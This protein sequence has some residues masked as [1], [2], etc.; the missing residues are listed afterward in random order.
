MRYNI[1]VN[2][3]AT[4]KG[5]TL[6]ELLVVVAIIGLLSSI[7]LASINTARIKGRDAKRVSDLEQVQNA[8]AL[9]YDDFGYYP[10]CYAFSP[11]NATHWGL[12][13]TPSCLY[14]LLVPTYIKSLPADPVNK[15]GGLPNFLGDNAPT[16]QGYRYYTATALTYT[17]GTNLEKGGTASEYGNFQIKN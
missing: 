10:P 14:T 17:L 7:V 6:I 12:S 15:E 3:L 2:R 5:F 13:G 11:W 4:K 8:L 9:F 1:A 16:D